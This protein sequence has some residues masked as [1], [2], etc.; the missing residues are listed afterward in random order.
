[1]LSTQKI[2]FCTTFRETTTRC[3]PF[4]ISLYP[5]SLCIAEKK[6]T[7]N[8][9]CWLPPFAEQWPLAEKDNLLFKIAVF[10]KIAIS[11][12]TNMHYNLQEI[13]HPA[14]GLFWALMGPM[15]PMGP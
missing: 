12:H 8:L 2:R 1:M 5:S 13:E 11:C 10:L 15:G 9:R 4:S 14:C 3:K 6:D 7:V